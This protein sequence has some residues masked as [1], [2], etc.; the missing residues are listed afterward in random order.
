MERVG[1]VFTSFYLNYFSIVLR[2]LLI[3]FQENFVITQVDMTKNAFGWL[4]LIEKHHLISG[5]VISLDTQRYSIS[6]H[7]KYAL[8]SLG[9]GELRGAGRSQGEHEF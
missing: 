6:W 1:C 8:E 9:L 5:T 3:I 4:L 2:L 7:D